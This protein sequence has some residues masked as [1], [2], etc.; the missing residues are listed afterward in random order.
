MPHKQILTRICG[1]AI[2]IIVI[3]AT[4]QVIIK[5]SI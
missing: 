1:Y 4:S 3:S 2:I 5:I